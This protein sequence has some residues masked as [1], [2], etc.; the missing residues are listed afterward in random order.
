[1]KLYQKVKVI[2]NI[3]LAVASGYCAFKSYDKAK[4]ERNTKN[5]VIN[6]AIAALSLAQAILSTKVVADELLLPEDLE[7]DDDSAEYIDTDVESE[8]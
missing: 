2:I 6:Y 5:K 3:V 7:E 1:M 4:C 8:F